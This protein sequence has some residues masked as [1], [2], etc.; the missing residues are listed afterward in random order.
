LLSLRL[1]GKDALSVVLFW[2]AA[3]AWRP[4]LS[5]FYSDDWSLLTNSGVGPIRL[6]E[7]LWIH[8]PRPLYAVLSWSFNLLLN[9]AVRS[10]TIVASVIVLVT[11]LCLFHYLRFLLTQLGMKDS[12]SRGALFG[13]AIWL[14]SPLAVVAMNWPSHTLT[15]I[16]FWFL[17]LGTPLLFKERLLPQLSGAVAL[18]ASFLIYEAYLFLFPVVLIAVALGSA[19]S[20]R[21][22]VRPMLLYL[23]AFALSAGYKEVAKAVGFGFAVFKGYNPLWLKLFADS[24]RGTAGL[25]D[26][27]FSPFT[28]L[29]Y[30]FGALFLLFAFLFSG[31]SLRRDLVLL[32]VIVAGYTSSAA[33][34]AGVGYGFA[35][36]GVMSRTMIGPLLYLAIGLA[37]FFAGAK[38]GVDRSVRYRKTK[39]LVLYGTASCLLVV[40]ASANLARSKEWFAVWKQ[41][42]A[43]LRSIPVGSIQKTLGEGPAPVVIVAWTPDDPYGS[44]FGA[45]WELTGAV[46]ANYPQLEAAIRH[47]DIVFLPGRDRIWKTQW[48]GANVEQRWQDNPGVVV[49]SH[50]SARAYC[51]SMKAHGNSVLSPFKAGRPD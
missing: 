37:G 19:W 22:C 32:F 35:A 24:M 21:R 29:I 36:T 26:Q 33:L 34:Y 11:A 47:K 5:G 38:D 43:M 40:S 13:T 49:E 8:S 17:S 25:L 6:S 51:F 14:L 4:L 20:V 1:P 15:L 23:A 7:Y 48:K 44:V 31:R 9:G 39:L 12:S 3:A 46:A 2:L 10:W 50:P 27:V 41:E 28:S 16:A 18:A 42:N 45:S 30:F